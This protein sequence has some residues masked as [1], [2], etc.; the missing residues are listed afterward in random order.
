[1]EGVLD[2]RL[3][4]FL[5]EGHGGVS[6]SFTLV[7]KVRLWGFPGSPFR[8]GQKQDSVAGQFRGGG[9]L[10]WSGGAL[11]GRILTCICSWRGDTFPRR[12][13]LISDLPRASLGH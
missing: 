6:C 1:M 9:W 7:A 11:A 8:V 3:R 13:S 12:H 5:V 2:G 4:F 10:K